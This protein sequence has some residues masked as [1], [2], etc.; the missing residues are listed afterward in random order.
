MTIKLKSLSIR[1][2]LIDKGLGEENI[3][4]SGICTY[5]LHCEFFSARRLG[6]ESGRIFNGIMVL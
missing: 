6:I 5:S 4:I 2:Q 1:L 3:H